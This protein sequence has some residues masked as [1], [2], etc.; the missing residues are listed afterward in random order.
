MV[1]SPFAPARLLFSPV[2]FQ[3][4][5]S[6]AQFRK[7]SRRCGPTRPPHSLFCFRL[8]TCQFQS[9]S[10]TKSWSAFLPLRALHKNKRINK[11]LGLKKLKKT[12]CGPVL[13]NCLFFR[14]WKG[15]ISSA[16]PSLYCT[17]KKPG[18]IHCLQQA[19]N[20]CSLA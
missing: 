8:L 16:I 3:P 14:T 10:R 18:K 4:S 5:T 15:P 2:N 11:N 1:F 6:P 9:D 17:G 13:T 12:S 19:L 20:T 7:A